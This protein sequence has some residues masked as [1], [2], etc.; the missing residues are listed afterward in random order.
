MLVISR[1]SPVRRELL[2]VA[3]LV[4]CSS[5]PD[6]ACLAELHE[7][8]TSGLDSPLYNRRVP[9]AQLAQTL[10]RARDA[11]TT[12]PFTVSES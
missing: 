7:L 12:P 3:A 1:A 5:D 4:R 10:N 9:A 11:L 2:E 8:L 6:P